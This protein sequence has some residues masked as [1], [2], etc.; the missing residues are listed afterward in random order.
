M[1]TKVLSDKV[2]T[3]KYRTVKRSVGKFIVTDSYTGNK[4][5]SQQWS[6]PGGFSKTHP[7]A[8]QP[9][10]LTFLYYEDISF[11]DSEECVNRFDSTD[12]ESMYGA[13]TVITDWDNFK[14][15]DH[16]IA[17]NISMD[18]NVYRINSPDPIPLWR[19]QDYTGGYSNDLYD[20]DGVMSVLK[21]KGDWIRNV[22]RITI[23]YYNQY[24]GCTEA[25]TFDYRL[26]TSKQLE[27]CLSADMKQY[28]KVDIDY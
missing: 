17:I 8:Y 27:A 24:R 13:D 3:V 23:P 20:L 5:T 21:S 11:I 7:I 19:F 6:V 26:P 22:E 4:L 10:N 18:G 15:F 14:G 9:S 16:V 2:K 1:K 25:V 12:I 28:K